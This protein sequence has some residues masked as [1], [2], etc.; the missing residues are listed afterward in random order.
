MIQI[1]LKASCIALKS[2]E[3]IWS[4]LVLTSDDRTVHMVQ[5]LSRITQRHSEWE[6]IP[7]CWNCHTSTISFIWSTRN[8]NYRHLSRLIQSCRKIKTTYH[9]V[10]SVKREPMTGKFAFQVSYQERVSASQVYPQTWVH[11]EMPSSDSWSKRNLQV[12]S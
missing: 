8:W 2:L 3:R 4:G 11:H 12:D 10:L 5:L 9:T 7:T 1:P 6:Y